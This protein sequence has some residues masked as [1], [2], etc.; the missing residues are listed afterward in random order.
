MPNLVEMVLKGVNATVF[1]YGVTGSG[2]THTMMGPP[3][4]SVKGLIQQTISFLFQE[5]EAQTNQ[6]KC[7]FQVIMSY[8]QIYNE[9]IRDLLLRDSRVQIDV[10]EDPTRGTVI[11]N[12]AQVAISNKEEVMELLQLGSSNRVTGAT[13][14]NSTSSRSHAIMQLYV[15][16][17]VNGFPQDNT[18]AKL[19]MIDLAGSERIASQNNI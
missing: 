6:E 17:E 10:N 5:I 7:G 9:Q 19:S 11:T 3:R 16:K 1:A 8:F 4:K 14:Q 12:L 2:K 15:T 18:F 13:D